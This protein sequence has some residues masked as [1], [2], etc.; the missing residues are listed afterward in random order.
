MP[1][2]S[3]LRQR[4]DAG[5]KLLDLATALANRGRSQLASF[6]ELQALALDD[7]ETSHR[8]RMLQAR[9][10]PANQFLLLNNDER[11]SAFQRAFSDLVSPG[12]LV[13]EIGTGSGI[14]AMLA[15]KAGAAQVITCEHQPLMARVAEMIVQ[16]NGLEHQIRVVPKGL[17][18]MELGTD[19][20]RR[21][22][23]LVGDLFTGALLEAGGLKLVRQA[24]E[25]LVSPD[26]KV[27]PSTATIR[28]RLV[29]GG[30]LDDLCRAK[31]SVELDISRFNLFS[32]PV[33]QILP[34]RF[35]TLRYHACSDVIDCFRF[36]FATLEGFK[37]SRR[38]LQ[39]AAQR[40]GEVTGFLQWL[41]LELSPGN[42]MESNETS[43]SAWSRYLH[44]FKKPIRLKAGEILRLHL[45]HDLN[46][47]SAWPEN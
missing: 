22:D 37:A 26:G 27:I 8:W 39:V 11:T 34:E 29:G 9:R 10:A 44:V 15:A 21:A 43:K 42:I 45:Q 17:H 24:K 30:E 1:L 3:E 19:L 28:G 25:K 4:P 41:R 32:P 12:D 47:F 2:L 20:P 23:V 36:D 33:V 14:L 38:I 7:P 16:D 40:D 31:A 46:R 18:D 5:S 35:A 13:L 6:V